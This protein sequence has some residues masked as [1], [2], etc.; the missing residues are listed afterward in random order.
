MTIGNT[1]CFIV[2]ITDKLLAN[3]I[4]EYTIKYTKNTIKSLMT[5]AF[6]L[7]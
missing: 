3:P 2:D 1:S 5:P 7:D 4:A 6:N